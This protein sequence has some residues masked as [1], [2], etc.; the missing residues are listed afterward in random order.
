MRCRPSRWLNLNITAAGAITAAADASIEALF[1]LLE[2]GSE[3]EIK[4]KLSKW[5][6]RVPV[7]VCYC[8][9]SFER[10]QYISK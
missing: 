5:K 7:F 2:L 3:E 6:M 10:R 1:G 8:L 9:L 4:K